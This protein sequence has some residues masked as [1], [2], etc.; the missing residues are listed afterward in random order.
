[1]GLWARLRRLGR[2]K[3]GIT[4]HLAPAHVRKVE[5]SNKTPALK[6]LEC[7]TTET[8][9]VYH[10]CCHSSSGLRLP[11]VWQNHLADNQNKT[12]ADPLRC[13]SKAA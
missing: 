10:Y 8:C 13:F 2:R 7:N 11:K 6:K 4:S 5:K 12:L 1:M 9:F 3:Q